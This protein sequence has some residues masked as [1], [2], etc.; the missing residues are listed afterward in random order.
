VQGIAVGHSGNSDSFFSTR[1][2][3]RAFPCIS[4]TLRTRL[5]CV[6]C[7]DTVQRRIA[8][9]KPFSVVKPADMLITLIGTP[10]SIFQG[11]RSWYLLWSLRIA[12]TIG[13]SVKGTC[14]PPRLSPVRFMTASVIFCQRPHTYMWRLEKA[15]MLT[16]SLALRSKEPLSGS[17]KDR[18]LE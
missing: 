11:H 7:A 3:L 18:T 17:A 1:P 15:S 16:S 4:L 14:K 13:C 2:L 12:V 5:R 9:D 8:R 10:Q 6:V